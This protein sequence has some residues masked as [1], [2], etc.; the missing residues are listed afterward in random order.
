MVT[1]CT[2]PLS[3]LTIETMSFA[4]A[5]FRITLK[6]YGRRPLAG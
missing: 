3:L 5:R 1:M 4:L 2:V 6:I